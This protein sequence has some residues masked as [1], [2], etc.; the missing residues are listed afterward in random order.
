MYVRNMFQVRKIRTDLHCQCRGSVQLFFVSQNLGLLTAY[1]PR[2]E[3]TV[4]LRNV[5]KYE[6]VSKSPRTMLITRKS[7]VVHEFPAWVC[8]GGV[9]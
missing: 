8:C 5:R 1:T 7:L 4:P 2:M 9:L 6:G 3:I